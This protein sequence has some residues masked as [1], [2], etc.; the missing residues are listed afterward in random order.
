MNQCRQL[1]ALLNSTADAYSTLD[2]PMLVRQKVTELVVMGGSYLEPGHSYNFWG[3]GPYVAAHA[4]NTW[5]GLVTFVGDE[6]GNY[7]LAGKALMSQGPETDPVRKAYIYYGYGKSLSSWDPLTILYAVNGLDELFKRGNE[8]GYNHLQANGSNRW[9]DDEQRKS[10]QFI[11]LKISNESAAARL[12]HI[13]LDTARRFAK[14]THPELET[15]RPNRSELYVPP[16][17]SAEEEC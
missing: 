13:L 16:D 4:L 7:V 6:V 12:D 11:K 1:S 2:G 17:A 9:I 14:S 3:S 5:E 8:F 15:Q 10:Q